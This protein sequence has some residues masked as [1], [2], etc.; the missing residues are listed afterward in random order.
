MEVSSKP[1][2]LKRIAGPVVTAIDFDA[3][4]YDVVKIGNEQLMGEVIKIDGAETV[5]QVYESTTGIRPGE[6]VI[7]TGLSLAVELGPG[8]LTS[9]YDGIQRPLEVLIQKMGNFIARGVTAPGLD[10]EKKWT[11]KPVVHVGDTV[12]PG[13]TIGEVQETR[14]ILHKVMIPPLA[15]GGKV[16]KINAGDFNVDQIVIELD[17]GESFPMMQKWPVRVP[18]PYVEKHSPSIPLLTGQRILDGLFPIAKGGTAAIPGPF[19]SGKTVTQQQL[20][21][22]SDAEIVVYIGCGERGNEMTEVL[23]EF[24]ELQD[25]KT[26]NSLME[27]TILIANT[28]NMPVAAREA[29]VYTGITL[30]EYFRD[31][32]YDVALMADSTSRWA[33][34]MRE[35]CSR[36]EEMPGEEG[37]PAYLSSRLS[38]FYERAGL[39]QPLG[40][41][42]G[43]VSV[44]GAVSPAGGDFSEPVTQNTLRIVKVFW[45]LD[46][47]LSRRRHFPAINWLQ[48][49]SLY[50]AQLNDYYDEKVSPEWNKL[51]AWFMEVLQKEAELLEIVQLV[52]SDALPETEQI[53]IEVARMIREL[54]LQQNGFDPVDTYCDLPKQLDMFKMIRSYAD[55]AYAA[56]VAGVPP[57]QILAVKAKNEMP[58]IK[59]TKDYKPVL[60]KIYTDME[61]EFKSLRA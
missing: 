39:V 14:S 38:E 47:N 55:L 27:R 11:F 3:H 19:G 4:M 7:N 15:K 43:S 60:A 34:A 49:Y 37:Y 35:I 28:S 2:I 58:Q 5:I 17:S 10:H 18:R 50:M 53:T 48:S 52:G 6:P 54:F 45:A 41:G 56:Q 51:R 12:A 8:L 40:G 25:P 30:A 22:W 1:G 29:S 57:S 36:L 20:A 21:K 42:S 46:A 26:G 13:Q 44:I 23:T 59:F 24:P 31:M 32:G 9:I 33:E 61:A 16:T